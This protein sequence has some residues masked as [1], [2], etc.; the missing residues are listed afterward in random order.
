M[1]F[2]AVAITAAAA[3]NPMHELFAKFKAE[4]KK[5][6][7]S[8]EEEAKRLEIFVK[9]VMF[10]HEQNAKQSSY[11]LEVNEFA[12]MS[13]EEFR[14]QRFGVKMPAKTAKLLGVHK[15]S[16]AALADEVDWTTKGA[17]TPVKNQG[18]C[19]SCWSFS[20]TGALEGANFVSTG[21]LVSLSEQ[22]FVDCDTVDQGCNGGLMDNAFQFAEQNAICTEDSYPYTATGGDCQQSSCTVGLAQGAVTGYTD[23]EQNEQAL[24]DAVNQQPVAIAIEADQQ[25]FQFYTSGVLTAECGTNLDHGVLLVGYGTENG[26][27]YWKV[28]NSWGESWG[29]QGYIKLARGVSQQGGQCGI[30]LAASYPTV[31]AAANVVV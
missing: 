18:Q 8:V 26:Q 28:K 27:D 14:T 13:R 15:Y 9:N 24:M 30:L 29:D 23:V 20:T 6:Y 11:K 16:G 12:D 31:A 2:F 3:F 10:I 4:F 22:E 21:N 7:K 19:G 5:E 1:R 17:V 25:A